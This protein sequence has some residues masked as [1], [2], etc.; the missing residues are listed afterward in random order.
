[1]ALL[2]WKNQY[3]LNGCQLN[4]LLNYSQM[5]FLAKMKSRVSLDVVKAFVQLYNNL[6]WFQ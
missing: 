6:G 4:G 1:M 3:P 2:H 5:K